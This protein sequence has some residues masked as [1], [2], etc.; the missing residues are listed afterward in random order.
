MYPSGQGPY[1]FLHPSEHIPDD[2]LC[3]VGLELKKIYF[4]LNLFVI[5]RRFLINYLEKSIGTQVQKALNCDIM[6]TWQKIII[7]V[8]MPGTLMGSLDSTI[9]IIA[10]PTL[11]D[12]LH[13]DLV[14]TRWIIPHPALVC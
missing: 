12:A 8:L 13:S 7:L 4:L 3:P 5:V 14:I 9:V 6:D 11:S 1:H 10:I 2:T